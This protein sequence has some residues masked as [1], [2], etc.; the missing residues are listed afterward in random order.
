MQPTH[1][2][3]LQSTGLKLQYA[4]KKYL[5]WAMG[6]SEGSLPLSHPPYPRI[7][8]G[9]PMPKGESEALHHLPFASGSPHPPSHCPREPPML[10]LVNPDDI[11][12]PKTSTFCLL[13]PFLTLPCRFSFFLI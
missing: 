11:F 10:G 6:A 8:P 5:K 12:T 4:Q 3:L 7:D 2:L 1:L 9:R 13:K